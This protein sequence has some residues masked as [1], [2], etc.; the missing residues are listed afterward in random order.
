MSSIYCQNLGFFFFFLNGCWLNCKIHSSG[1]YDAS[2]TQIMPM[3]LENFY[4]V[5]YSHLL[6][7]VALLITS[8]SL[9]SFNWWMTLLI[10]SLYGGGIINLS[11]APDCRLQMEIYSL[12]LLMS[13]Q[14]NFLLGWRLKYIKHLTLGFVR[15]SWGSIIINKDFVLYSSW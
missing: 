3:L 5:S 2:I 11:L 10:G 9:Y 7:Q 1:T 6:L 8:R 14:A 4:F 12:L 13:N 15:S